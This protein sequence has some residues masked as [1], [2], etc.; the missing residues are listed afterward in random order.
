MTM[1]RLRLPLVLTLALAT[2]VAQA[3]TS[4]ALFTDSKTAA[5]NTFGSATWAFYLHNNPTPPAGD[6]AAQVNLVMNATTPTAATLYQYSTGCVARAGRRITRA[7]PNPNQATACNY[8]NWR[9]PVLAATLRLSGAITVDIWSAADTANANQTAGIVAYL[10]DFNPAGTG[11]YTEI[12]NGLFTTTY[13]IGRTFYHYP[14]TVTVASAYTVPVGHQLELKLVASNAYQA[15]VLVAY[16]TTTY[17]SYLR[18]R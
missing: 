1:R 5:A 18:V 15:P 9:T 8:V 17:R 4:L 3:G 10:R 6:T 2:L 14:I 16:D 7:A 12:A 11:S 13:A